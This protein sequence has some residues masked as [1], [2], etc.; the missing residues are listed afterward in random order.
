MTILVNGE[1]RVFDTKTC[2][3]NLHRIHLLIARNAPVRALT[4]R[5]LNLRDM[6]RCVE[7]RKDR[8]FLSE[9]FSGSLI[10]VSFPNHEEN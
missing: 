5:D 6:N 1:L 8:Q 10:Q 2:I 7:S 4:L 9:V 3:A